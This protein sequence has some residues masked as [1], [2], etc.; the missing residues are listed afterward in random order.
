M[1]ELGVTAGGACVSKIPANAPWSF[2]DP[3]G[4]R[5]ISPASSA[6]APCS[7]SG[8]RSSFGA[9]QW[10]A[11][12]NPTG[13]AYWQSWTQTFNAA[14][15]ALLADVP[16]SAD[17]QGPCVRAADRYYEA[18]LAIIACPRLAGQNPV[19]YARFESADASRTIR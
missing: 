8:P 13:F 19:F 2:P 3:R 7:T 9:R 6:T 5:A 15:A 16:E 18:A 4:L 12:D 1:T 17:D 11:P 10:L 14:E